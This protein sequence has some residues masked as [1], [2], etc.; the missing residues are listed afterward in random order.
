MHFSTF[1]SEYNIFENSHWIVSILLV[2]LA[3]LLVHYLEI[4]V[5][6]R[7]YERLK[8]TRFLWDDTLLWAVHAPLGL[9]IWLWGITLATQIARFRLPFP[10]LF[11]WIDSFCT[12]GTILAFTW[13]LLR[14]T[15]RAEQKM[16]AQDNENNFL[17][18]Q[19]TFQAFAQVIQISILVSAGLI[20]LKY[21][22]D[23]SFTGLWAI[24]G[25]GSFVIGWAAKDLLANFFGAI[26]IYMDRPFSL[27][28]WIRSPDREIEGIVEFIGWRL[29]IIRTFD[30]RPLYIPNS[31]F[32][33]ICVENVSKTTYR[34]IKETIGIDF[35]DIN[36][37]E[38]IIKDIKEMLEKHPS[39]EPMMTCCVNL[40][41]VST[42]SLNISIV[43]FT[44]ITDWVSFLEIKQDIMLQVLKLIQQHGAELASPISVLK[45]PE[46][47]DF[48]RP[49]NENNIPQA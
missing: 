7:I 35:K 3:T 48:L 46:N 16:L 20:F 27:G 14:V 19:T 8:N 18:D 40:I 38:M 25:I 43:C 23:F 12:F 31:L 9:M 24:G 39:V 13:F 29:T 15:R 37:L 17:L 6:S 11:N 22:F 26:M 2:I 44:K 41:G 4:R 30:K 28:D 47:I 1:L 32:A 36:Q 5:Y 10:Q 21:F 42:S 49:H 34:R 33:T 45:V